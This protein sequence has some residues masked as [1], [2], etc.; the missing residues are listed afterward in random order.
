ME[1][2]MT[3]ELGIFEVDLDGRFSTV[4]SKES[5]L[6]NFV[7]DI[8]VAATEADFALINSGTFRSDTI[9]KAGSF[10]IKDLLL[11]LPMIDPLVLV[12]V[13]GMCKTKFRC[14]L[15]SVNLNYI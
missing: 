9:H 12:E 6:C 10:T 14:K 7:A 3:K 1:G 13:T 8:M 2:E 5:N 11:V 4:R 15:S